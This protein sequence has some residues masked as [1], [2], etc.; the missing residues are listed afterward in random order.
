MLSVIFGS[1]RWQHDLMVFVAHEI[2]P[3]LA[4]VHFS[5]SAALWEVTHS[6]L[7]VTFVSQSATFLFASI[8][9]FLSCLPCLHL[10][11]TSI[12]VNQIS[13]DR[14]SHVCIWPLV[15]RFLWG[16]CVILKKHN[17]PYKYTWI[18]KLSANVMLTGILRYCICMYWMGFS[19]LFSFKATLN[20]QFKIS[21]FYCKWMVDRWVGGSS[22]LSQTFQDTQSIAP[23]T[24]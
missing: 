21:L 3:L 6:L 5:L 10:I 17:V 14:F 16:E 8:S 12:S 1:S 11:L 20:Q 19:K 13:C 24:Q 4:T 18:F 22:L 15:N 7:H 9:G 2:R 23:F